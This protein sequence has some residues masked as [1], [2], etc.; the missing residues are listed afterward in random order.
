MASEGAVTSTAD[1]VLEE[2]EGGGQAGLRS[3]AISIWLRALRAAADLCLAQGGP[4]ENPL[5]D[6]MRF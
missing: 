6:D 5:P 3:A 1:E 4:E 2:D